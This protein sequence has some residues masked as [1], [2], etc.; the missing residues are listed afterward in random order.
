MITFDSD[1][2]AMVRR[3]IAGSKNRSAKQRVYKTKPLVS[4]EKA[5]HKKYKAM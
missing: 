3:F 2:E 4:S 5:D 1:T